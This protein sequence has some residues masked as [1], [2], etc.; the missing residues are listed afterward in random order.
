MEVEILILWPRV[1]VYEVN[2]VRGQGGNMG[3]SSTLKFGGAL[4]GAEV[5]STS[6][7]GTHSII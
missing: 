1:N 3:N 6:R 7:T 5:A 4:R 2:D